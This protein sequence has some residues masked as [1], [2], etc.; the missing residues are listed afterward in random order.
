MNLP[1]Q[2]TLSRIFLTA[3][4]M[5]SLFKLG[6]Y[7]KAASLAIFL[8]ASL[9]DYLDG[10]LAR[11]YRQVTPFGQIMD[12]IA[13]KILVLAAFLAF[14][15]LGFIPAWMVVVLILRELI[16]TGL[17]LF[18][19][20]RG[21]VHEA[22]KGGKHKTI[23]QFA[24]IIFILLFFIAREMPFWRVE[25]DLVMVRLIHLS[26]WGVVTMTIISGWRYVRQH[27]EILRGQVG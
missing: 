15:E 24:V 25:W 13:D 19:V 17:R 18:L 7:W 22:D 8:T 3:L 6:W 10:A 23:S 20:S 14:V 5:A 4:F 27:Q 1:N 12:P 16:I 2:L 9:T 26:M 21:V 11:R